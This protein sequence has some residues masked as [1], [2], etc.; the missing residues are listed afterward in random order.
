LVTQILF[1]E[2]YRLWSSLCHL[3][4]SPV[5]SSLLGPHVFLNTLFSHTSAHVP[6]SISETKFH[7]H[8][9]QDVKL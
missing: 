6:P 5:I 8:I 9:K 4:Q 7:T 3:L 1:G 2:K